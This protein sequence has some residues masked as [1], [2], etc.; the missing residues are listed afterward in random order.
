MILRFYNAGSSRQAAK[1]FD[2]WR[3]I[4]TGKKKPVPHVPTVW[5]CEKSRDNA[6]SAQVFPP[7]DMSLKTTRPSAARWSLSSAYSGWKCCRSSTGP[8]PIPGAALANM[9]LFS[10]ILSFGTSP[11]EA[12]VRFQRSLRM[13]MWHQWMLGNE[14]HSPTRTFLFPATFSWNSYSRTNQQR[15]QEVFN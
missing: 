1:H 14:Q 10:W 2:Y 4:W 7:F 8:H 6:A 5:F 12:L 9:I 13:G 11:G 15:D 3:F